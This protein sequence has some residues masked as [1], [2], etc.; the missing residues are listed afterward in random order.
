M[1]EKFIKY[2]SIFSI[3]IFILSY[4]YLDG[5]YSSFNIDVANYFTTSEIFYAL[6][7]LVALLFGCGWLAIQ[8]L[9]LREDVDTRHTSAPHPP[10]TTCK[11][12]WTSKEIWLEIHLPNL[13]ALIA[14][15]GMIINFV[16]SNYRIA[17][18]VVSIVWIGMYGCILVAYFLKYKDA[19]FNIYLIVFISF[20][21]LGF[22]VR[23]FGKDSARITYILGN[24]N[25]IRFRYH[26]KAFQS[27]KSLIF[28]GE[29]QST[30][31][32]FNKVDSTTMI[33]PRNSIDSLLVKSPDFD[34]N[35]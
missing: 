32:L 25:S 11:E 27:G 35:F 30:V 2:L 16:V 17:P 29:C 28:V 19:G 22:I 18:T 7:P 33:L 9:L 21:M 13:F 8:G 26:S 6:L 4:A 23:Q 24:K 34:S 10:Q 3:G 12:L 5:Y 20:I 15:E 14:G 31:F 1:L